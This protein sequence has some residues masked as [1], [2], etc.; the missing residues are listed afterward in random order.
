MAAD[1]TRNTR[2][3]IKNGFLVIDR[4]GNGAIDD[5][6]EMFGAPDVGGYAELAANDNRIERAA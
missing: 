3:S 5:I 6:T 1:V 2:K 4:N